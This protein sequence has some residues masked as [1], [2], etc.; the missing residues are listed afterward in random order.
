M[1]NYNEFIAD[2]SSLVAIN[3]VQGEKKR[4]KPFGEGPASALNTFLDIANRMGFKTKNYKNYIGEI[5]VGK[6]E[7]IGVIGHL[8][9]VPAGDGWDFDPFTLTEKDGYLYGRGV[10]DDKG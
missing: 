8:D 3:S 2:L 6:G 10:E 9:I 4:G 7:E 5:S 1:K